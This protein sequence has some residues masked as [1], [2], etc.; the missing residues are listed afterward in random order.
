MVMVYRGSW[1]DSN[2]HRKICNDVYT[3]FWTGRWIGEIP[4]C[5]RFRRL[6]DLSERRGH[7]WLTA[8]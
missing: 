4:L 7:Q 1:F 5:E 2:V 8:V 6:F 3:F